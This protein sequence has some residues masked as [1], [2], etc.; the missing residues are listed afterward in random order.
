MRI[1]RL[2]GV[3]VAV[4]SRGSPAERESL[5]NQVELLLSLSLAAF[6]FAQPN[7][8]TQTPPN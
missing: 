3:S 7:V 1:E 6:S 8:V 2:G 5:R 4:E